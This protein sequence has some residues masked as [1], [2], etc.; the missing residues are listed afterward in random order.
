MEAMTAVTAA[1]LT[2]YDMVKAVDRFVRIGD[3]EL[4]EKSGGKSGHVMNPR[5]LIGRIR[6]LSINAERGQLKE[7][8]ETVHLKPGWGIEGDGHGGDWNRQV[9]LLSWEGINRMALRNQSPVN[10]GEMAENI[11]SEGIELVMLPIGS[12]LRLGETAVVRV[13]QIGKEDHPSV[14][15][16]KFGQSLIPRQGIF[17]VVEEEGIIKI[18]D[19]VTLVSS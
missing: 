14:V 10:P 1:G 13:T 17:V 9:S 2:V 7:P 15:T 11:V 3:A 16:R 18:G 5:A 8:V 12:L 19:E 4:I 6:S